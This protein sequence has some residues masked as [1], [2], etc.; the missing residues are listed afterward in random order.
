MKFVIAKKQRFRKVEENMKNYDEVKKEI[1]NMMEESYPDFIKALFSIEAGIEDLQKLDDMY[2]EFMDEDGYNLLSDDILNLATESKTKDDL[3]KKDGLVNIMGYVTKDVESKIIQ[4]KDDKAV[5]VANFS[6]I[7]ENSKGKK[8][9]TNLSAFD[10]KIEEYKKGDLV[11]VF[12]KEKISVGSDG[13]RYKNVNV[14][15][16]ELIQARSQE[17]KDKKSTLDSINNLKEKAKEQEGKH[18]DDVIKEFEF[19]L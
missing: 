4:T 11:K 13:K 7:L 14:L 15:K 10:D 8:E 2:N 18:L 17:N 1:K 5:E 16:S 3:S 9:Y 6:I 12:G 19:G